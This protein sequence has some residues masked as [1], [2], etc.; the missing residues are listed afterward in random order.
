MFDCSVSVCVDTLMYSTRKSSMGRG[1]LVA[2]SLVGSQRSLCCLCLWMIKIKEEKKQK[3]NSL[4][5]FEELDLRLQLECELWNTEGTACTAVSQ[6]FPSIVS[7]FAKDLLNQPK[8]HSGWIKNADAEITLQYDVSERSNVLCLMV[9]LVKKKQKKTDGHVGQHLIL[10]GKV[11]G[12]FWMK[13]FTFLPSVK[14]K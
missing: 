11:D 12:T 7:K 1:R 4:S 14:G 6:F 9:A 8:I 13:C 3:K 10:G 2:G 5:S